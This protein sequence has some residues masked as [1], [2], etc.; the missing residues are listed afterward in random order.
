MEEKAPFCTGA[1]RK[2]LERNQYLDWANRSLEGWHGEEW[3]CTLGMSGLGM[4]KCGIERQDCN[5]KLMLLSILLTILLTFSC[6]Q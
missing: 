1:L 4:V 3:Y 6:K 2:M 5:K